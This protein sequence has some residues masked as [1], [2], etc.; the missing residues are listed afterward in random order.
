MEK[1]VELPYFVVGR[2]GD[3]SP[4]DGVVTFASVGVV[5]VEVEGNLVDVNKC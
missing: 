3:R 5:I 2:E 4:D 1:A